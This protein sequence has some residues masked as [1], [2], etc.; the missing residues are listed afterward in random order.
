[1][2]DC[3]FVVKGTK[4]NVFI[5]MGVFITG[6]LLIIHGMIMRD[7]IGLVHSFFDAKG[8]IMFNLKIVRILISFGLCLES[9]NLQFQRE[10][11]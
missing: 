1:M 8:W 3:T 2:L 11:S 9:Y 5:A 6:A 10:F 7:G 4:P